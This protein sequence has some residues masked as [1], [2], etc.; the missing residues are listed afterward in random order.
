[1]QMTNRLER[2]A[3]YAAVLVWTLCSY[4]AIEV[5]A[6]KA[7]AGFE[8]ATEE[9]KQIVPLVQAAKSFKWEIR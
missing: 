5:K 1:M 2:Y 6:E 7:E 4:L 9:L 3:L 8:L